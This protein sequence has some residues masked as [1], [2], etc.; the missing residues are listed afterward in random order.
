MLYYHGNKHL[1][2]RSLLYYLPLKLLHAG[3]VRG[4]R[5]GRNRATAP[6]RYIVDHSDAEIENSQ[7]VPFSI[8][9]LHESYS[10]MAEETLLMA[11]CTRE[12]TRMTSR[13]T[14][15]SGSEYPRPTKRSGHWSSEEKLKYYQFLVKHQMNFEKRELRRLD[16]IFK[17]MSQHLGSRA[18][19]QC[20]SHHQKMEKKYGSFEALMSNFLFDEHGVAIGV[21]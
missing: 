20:R 5:A 18:A 7:A 17:L 11:T 4:K 2:S 21:K 19:D 10:L 9:E 13:R 3:L 1:S 12:I 14:R 16:K 15:G 6:H 8:G